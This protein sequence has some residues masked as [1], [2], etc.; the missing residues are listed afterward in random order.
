VQ[1]GRF[2]TGFLCF[3]LAGTRLLTGVGVGFFA[4]GF[5]DT[6]YPGRRGP[7]SRNI[8]IIRTPSL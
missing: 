8:S 7:I 5:G 4:I 6:L 1:G 3:F 2:G